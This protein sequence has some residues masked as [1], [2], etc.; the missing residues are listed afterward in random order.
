MLPFAT[1]IPAVKTK[2]GGSGVRSPHYDVGFW[3]VFLFYLI[4]IIIPTSR[5]PRAHKTQPLSSPC[6]V[7]RALHVITCILTDDTWDD[8]GKGRVLK[9][10]LPLAV[11]LILIFEKKWELQ[12]STCRYM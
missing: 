4:Y 3:G 12:H 7:A 2:V 9:A 6:R 1:C 10:P 8:E 5:L 11:T